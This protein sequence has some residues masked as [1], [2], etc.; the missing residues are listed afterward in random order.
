[1][2][3]MR[4]LT[5]HIIS[6][7][8]NICYAKALFVVTLLVHFA[9]ESLLAHPL[10]DLYKA[11]NKQLIEKMK[12][13][14]GKVIGGRELRDLK[15]KFITRSW[16]DERASKLE[17]LVCTAEGFRTDEEQV[18]SSYRFTKSFHKLLDCFCALVI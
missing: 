1:M 3:R 2:G 4:N 16:S 12:W 13:V 14:H 11:T 9:G 7:L 15:R 5:N 17:L 8:L 18:A 10:D 6:N